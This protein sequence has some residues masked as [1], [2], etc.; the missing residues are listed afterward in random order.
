M[1]SHRAAGSTHTELM[2]ALS[3]ISEIARL[4]SILPKRIRTSLARRTD[5]PFVEICLDVGRV[6]ELRYLSVSGSELVYDVGLVTHAD[7]EEISADL[8]F[9]SDNRA[10]L[11]GTLHRISAI[12]N[13]A[14]N[15]DGLT[16]RIGSEI[17]DILQGL[18]IYGPENLL[19]LGPPMSG[20][21]SYLRS[22]AKE[23]S[24][25][26]R[27]LIVDT[28]DEICGGA[29]VPHESVGS[30]RR[31]SV[32]HRSMQHEVLIEAVQN[33]SPE[34]IIVDELG[35][36]AEV[37]AART[38][39]ERGVRLI[40]TVHGTTL[41][42]LIANPSMNILVGGVDHVTIGDLGAVKRGGKKT[43]S[44]RITQ[45]VFDT[46]I[47]LGSGRGIKVLTGVAKLVDCILRRR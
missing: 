45:P 27:V 37:E 2:K 43:V 9:S 30:A 46:V 10:G 38:I 24:Q 26:R 16:C 25:T 11:P 36:V 44:E 28:S 7:I 35:T 6:P 33:H 23:L 34:V 13:R 14:G 41:E 32:S 8:D 42:N 40:S 4:T 5:R 47:E 17:P 12:R 21:T 31:M 3:N 29:G 20:K 1:T 15:I 39:A 19:F 18:D 22:I